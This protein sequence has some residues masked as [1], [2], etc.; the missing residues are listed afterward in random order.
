[1]IRRVAFDVSLTGVSSFLRAL[2][3]RNRR[4]GCV[5]INYEFSF[6]VRKSEIS[7]A[8]KLLQPKVCRERI[9]NASDSRGDTVLAATNFWPY[10]KTWL[11]VSFLFFF[12]YVTSV[13]SFRIQWHNRICI[14]VAYE[15][16]SDV[17]IHSADAVSR[18]RKKKMLAKFR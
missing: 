11:T 13:I 8:W 9:R 5:L 2:R 15:F 1:M 14:H 10:A 7:S 6:R 3:A 4:Y 16:L 17:L 12:N 18:N